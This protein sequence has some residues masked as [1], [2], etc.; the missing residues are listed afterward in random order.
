MNKVNSVHS[1]FEWFI[2]V[3]HFFHWIFLRRNSLRISATKN[4]FRLP[5]TFDLDFSFLFFFPKWMIELT[6]GGPHASYCNMHFYQLTFAPHPGR[7]IDEYS[8]ASYKCVVISFFQT[9]HQLCSLCCDLRWLPPKSKTATKSLPPSAHLPL[10]CL[11]LRAP[12]PLERPAKS[13][14][15]YLLILDSFFS[16]A[17]PPALALLCQVIRAPAFRS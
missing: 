2:I 10:N 6:E 4:L 1:R 9:S 15:N 3:H 14:G 8:M 7:S 12:T 16:P 5:Y 13:S 11:P 17:H